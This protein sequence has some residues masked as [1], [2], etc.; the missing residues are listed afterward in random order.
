MFYKNPGKNH[1]NSFLENNILS[2]NF[3]AYVVWG[4][5]NFFNKVHDQN[6]LF[7]KFNLEPFKTISKFSSMLKISPH[8]GIEV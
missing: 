5:L 2:C 7:L 6:Y 3:S 8:V 1:L 4:Y